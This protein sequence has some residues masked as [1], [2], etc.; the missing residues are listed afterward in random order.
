MESLEARHSGPLNKMPI[1]QTIEAPETERGDVQSD[2]ATYRN[3]PRLTFADFGVDTEFKIDFPG[4]NK[5]RLK[6]HK[7]RIDNEGTDV[8]YIV[9]HDLR[10]P[11]PTF[12]LSRRSIL[13]YA[14]RNKIQIL[15]EC[16]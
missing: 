16:F 13:F 4:Y 10:D 5:R 8:P 3:E 9:C 7:V 14:E 15:R 1:A 12:V 2:P 11:G 6:V